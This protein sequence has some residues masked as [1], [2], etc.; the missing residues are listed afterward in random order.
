MNLLGSCFTPEFGEVILLTD[1]LVLAIVL[2]AA[3]YDW[4]AGACAKALH[5]ALAML[6]L[7][8]GRF[9]TRDR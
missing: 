4:I 8:T 3:T 6:A 1:G 9:G 2:A 5:H 7:V